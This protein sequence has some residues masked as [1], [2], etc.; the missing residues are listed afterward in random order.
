MD[1]GAYQELRARAASWLDG[2]PDEA[3]RAELTGILGRRDRDELVERFS[4]SLTFGTAGLRGLLGAGPNRMNRAVVIRTSL[5]LVRTI[6]AE[7]PRA[8]ERGIVIGYDARHYSDVFARDAAEVFAAARVKV[9]WFEETATTPLTAFAVA[10]LGAAAGVMVTASHNPAAYNGYKAYGPNGAQIVPPRDESV[11][12][13]IAAAPAANRVPRVAF[14]DARAQ[15]SIAPIGDEVTRAYLSGVTELLRARE[16]RPPLRI[17]YTP[18][19][20][21]GY[22]LAARAFVAAGFSDLSSV[23]EQTRP[24]PT[25]PTVR[26][27]NPEERGALDLAIAHARRTGCD[28]IL[29]NDPDADRLAVAVKDESGAFVQLSGNQVG[30][31]LGHYVLT[32]DPRRDARAVITTIVSSPM[33]GEMARELGI[34]YEETLTGFKWIATRAIELEAQGTRFVFGYEEA[35]GYSVGSL[36]RDKDGVSAAVLFAELAAVCRAQGTSVLAYLADLYRRFGYFA[37]VQRNIVLEG[38]AGAAKIAAMMTHLRA[39]PP[40]SIGGRAVQERRDYATGD[41]AGADGAVAKLTLPASNVLSY[42]LDGG[43]RIVIR[44]SGTEPKLKYYIDHREP[45]SVDEPLDI[46]D[47][48]ARAQIVAI[49]GAVDALLRSVP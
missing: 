23:P 26:F 10:Y 12:Q 36:V 42:L 15:G 13:A 6:L 40:A 30:A 2:D 37:S 1:E 39:H 44:P 7:V 22:A 21:V 34:H 25:F 29:A 16:V 27:P 35:L 14:D 4:E 9:H 20:G 8:A 17:A 11:A 47:K 49:D 38:T 19:H 18:M 43:T 46:A 41:I 32:Q 3:T 48:R 5:G 33:L 45:V 31:L 28:L 24:D